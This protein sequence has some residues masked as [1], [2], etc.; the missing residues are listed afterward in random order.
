M[1]A[2]MKAP[3]RPWIHLLL[4]LLLLGTQGIVLGGLHQPSASHQLSDT[5]SH[6]GA[7]CPQGI[8][9][10]GESGDNPLC[11]QLCQLISSVGPTTEPQPPFSLPLDIELPTATIKD[12]LSDYLPPVEHGP[13]R[14]RI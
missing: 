10:A 6:H 13:P 5:M 3:T 1:L 8:Y 4:C 12:R 7:D 2:L 9:C 14:S 11:D